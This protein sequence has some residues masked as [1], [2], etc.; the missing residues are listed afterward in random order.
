MFIYLF[1]LSWVF[2]AVLGLSLVVASR[3]SSLVVVHRLLSSI[4]SMDSVVVANRLRCPE[5][6]GIFLDQGSN[7]C[8]LHWQADSQPLDHQGSP[9]TRLKVFIVALLL[10]KKYKLLIN[11]SHLNKLKYI[12]V[13]KTHKKI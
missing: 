1:W 13:T 7:P 6:C 11:S 3:N 4:G 12:F 5:V 9:S 10:W 2:L 8:A